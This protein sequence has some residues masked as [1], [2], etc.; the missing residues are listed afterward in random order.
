MRQI[1]PSY[2]TLLR[3]VGSLPEEFERRFCASRVEALLQTV[4][5]DY[6]SFQAKARKVDFLGKFMTV[7]MDMVLKAGRMEPVAPPPSLQLGVS[8][9]SSGKI[10][11]DWI[12]NPH[13]EPEVIFVTYEEF[14]AIA[15]KLK[16]RLLKGTIV[17][18]SEEE[19]PGWYTAWL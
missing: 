12:G 19:I 1:L 4:R 11:P 14:M 9:S 18:A 2:I 16:E 6:E 3:E 15:R 17:P 10:E 13:R 8:I 7:G 5:T